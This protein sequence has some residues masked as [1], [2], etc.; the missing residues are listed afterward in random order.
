MAKSTYGSKNG[1]DNNAIFAGDGAAVNT[2][3]WGAQ[4]EVGDYMT[5][6]IPSKRI[7]RMLLDIFMDKEPEH[8]EEILV[9]KELLKAMAL[10]RVGVAAL[11]SLTRLPVEEQRT[12]ISQV[13]IDI[14]QEETRVAGI[15]YKDQVQKTYSTVDSCIKCTR[16]DGNGIFFHCLIDAEAIPEGAYDFKSAPNYMKQDGEQIHFYGGIPHVLPVETLETK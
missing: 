5:S 3:F 10:K 9:S 14:I 11:A 2:Y 4:L 12:K 6:Y 8:T 1:A 16:T 13:Q 7:N 15:N